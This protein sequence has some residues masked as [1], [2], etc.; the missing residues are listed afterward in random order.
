MF[1]P[2]YRDTEACSIAEVCYVYVPSARNE[3]RTQNGNVKRQC[4]G[5]PSMNPVRWHCSFMTAKFVSLPEPSHYFTLT[6]KNRKFVCIFLFAF[7]LWL[8]VCTTAHVVSSSHWRVI[9]Y[10]Y[11]YTHLHCFFF[12]FL[13]TEGW[14]MATDSHRVETFGRPGSSE[15]AF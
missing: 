10:I 5:F 2:K 3:V 11:I 15:V 7:Y 8:T 1:T 4:S 6:S 9:F 13:F 12:F 14:V